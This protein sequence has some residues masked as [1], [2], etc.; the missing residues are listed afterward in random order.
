MG[1]S[2]YSE[3]KRSQMMTVNRRSTISIAVAGIL[4]AAGIIG[5]VTV[6]QSAGILP[7]NFLPI[8]TGFLAVQMTDPPNVPENVTDI[9]IGYSDIQVHLAATTNQSSS[10]FTVAKAGHM[11]LMHVLNVSVTL[12]VAKVD[13]GRFDLVRFDISS[14]Q[15]TYNGKNYSAYVPSNTMS[16][17]IPHGGV[18]VTNNETTA[19]IID[20]SPT[21]VPFQNGPSLGFVLVPAAVCIPI[22]ALDWSDTLNQFGATLDTNASWF[23]QSEIQ[24]T[25]N[26]TIT[27]SALTNHSIS[28]A[29]RNYGNTN[30]TISE[31]DLIEN[32]TSNGL[33]TIA[34]FQVLGNATI[35]PSYVDISNDPS[36]SVGFLLVTNETVTFTY[37]GTI[38]TG[39]GIGCTRSNFSPVLAGTLYYMSVDGDLADAY[40]NVTAGS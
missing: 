18:T 6:L 19:M 13:V 26:I 33:E 29:V 15:V 31:L 23:Q 9:Y 38:L 34:S 2:S 8:N 36:A 17:P 3:R 22:P 16:I 28:I 27:E 35:L 7:T 4:V 12:G 11:D 25:S 30:V 10:W 1:I 14:A 24:Q 20:M 5:G 39:C 40:G 21:V 32:S 37:S